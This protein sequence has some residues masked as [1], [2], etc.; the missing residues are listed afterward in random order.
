MVKKLQKT[1][2]Q[3]QAEKEEMAKLSQDILAM[4]SRIP[5][6]V[7]NETDFYGAKAFKTTAMAARKQAEAKRP[8]VEKLRSAMQS[9]RQY[10]L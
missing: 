6:R 10:Y 4:T 7:M 2:S 9:I 1:E 8:T 3:V 5:A